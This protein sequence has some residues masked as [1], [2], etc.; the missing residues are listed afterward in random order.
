MALQGW[1]VK[2][3]SVFDSDEFAPVPVMTPKLGT[4]THKSLNDVI[5]EVLDAEVSH[6]AFVVR[7]VT[8]PLPC[9][10]DHHDGSLQIRTGWGGE[11]NVRAY[12]A[13]LRGCV[14]STG[15]QQVPVYE[16]RATIVLDSKQRS[17]CLLVVGIFDAHAA[18]AAR[19]TPRRQPNCIAAVNACKQLRR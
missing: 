10:D 12:S 19:S 11:G 9:C 7:T 8:L 13:L 16:R 5:K 3:T 15:V 14:F 18:S 2:L 4:L 6:S 1:D 17:V